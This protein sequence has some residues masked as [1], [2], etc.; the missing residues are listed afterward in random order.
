LTLIKNNHKLKHILYI[1][2]LLLI[3]IINFAQQ[4][5]SLQKVAA[6]GINELPTTGKGILYQ[7]GKI[8]LV[9]LVLLTIFGAIIFYLFR[10]EKKIAKIEKEIINEA[11]NNYKQQH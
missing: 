5:T 7:Q 4:D 9:V 3:P 11:N 10:L 6:K 8:Y 2:S 1:L